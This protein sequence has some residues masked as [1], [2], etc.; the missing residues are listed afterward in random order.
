MIKRKL[1]AFLLLI[2]LSLC[3]LLTACGG[4][5]PNIS[6]DEIPE[7]AGNAYI[8]INENVPFFTDDEIST[9]PLEKY[10]ELDALGRCGVAFACIGLE[11]MPTDKREDIGSVTPSGWKYN[12][13]SN[14]NSYDFVDGGFIY[15]RCHL[16]GFQ[17]AGENANEK[18]LITGTRY[19]NIEGMLPFENQIADYVKATE[20]H[21]MFR[22]TPMFKGED[23]VA[24]GVL[25]EAVSV[26]DSGEGIKFCVYAYNVQP[27]VKINYFTGQ[28]VLSGEELPPVNEEGGE[29]EGVYTYVI[30]TNSKTVHS[31]ECS[32][33][34]KI[35]ESNRLE[36]EGDVEILIEEFAGYS[37]C[38][39]CLPDLV[40]PPKDQSGTENEE[41]PEGEGSDK[42]ET[43]D[44]ND[45]ANDTTDKENSDITT[46]Y[47]VIN[48]N[49]K[50]VHLSSC[51]SA[52]KISEANRAE[53]RGDK[54]ALLKEYAGYKACKSC[55]SDLVIPEKVESDNS[56]VDLSL[57]F[58]HYIINLTTHKY[59]LTTC[60]YL[61]ELNN[62]D[63]YYGK[64]QYF[65]N[66]F[67]DAIPCL[68]CNPHL[69]FK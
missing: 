40:I 52:S 45:E 64:L 63:A 37:A 8:A 33:A 55:L 23:L 21:V 47:Y 29:N 41:S 32:S 51:S 2:L 27:G 65:F 42:S 4:T 44:D 43:T 7:F 17:L 59:H 28:N 54:E 36:F 62:S 18:N 38:K 12:K 35:S 14:N 67:P 3:C 69:E 1:G 16:I 57:V 61:P 10:S 13:V 66:R 26:E 5:T 68:S 15:N 50:T 25:M 31:S 24:S 46:L 49:T 48:T 22:A 30:N 20:N 39:S 11:T 19:L 56:Q 6:L 58:V 53:F 9:D 60:I 34:K